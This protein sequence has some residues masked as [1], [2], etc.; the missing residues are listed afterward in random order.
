MIFTKNQYPNY[1]IGPHTYGQITIHG[2]G[3]DTDGNEFV[4]I[5]D[6][7]SFG[8]GTQ[9]Q[10]GADHPLT[11]VSTYPFAALNKTEK[12]PFDKKYGIYIGNDVWTG[13][14]VI[15]KHGV[16]IG[17]GAVIGMGS[18]VTHDVDP[19][20][21]VVGNPA[22]LLRYRFEKQIIRDLL[23]I[24]W[25]NWSEAEIAERLPDMDDVV[26]FCEKYRP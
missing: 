8:P 13:I 6:Y 9:L 7:C 20:S 19:Y 25:W 11:H 4:R 5:G 24:Q 16:T 12:I 21:I 2:G 26:S 15:V 17:D 1:P 3:L 14:N 23:K 22:R 10:L 18:V